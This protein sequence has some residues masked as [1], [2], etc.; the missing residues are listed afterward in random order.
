MKTETS[1]QLMTL[2]KDGI[3]VSWHGPW[4]TPS[5]HL[6]SCVV[7]HPKDGGAEAASTSAW[8]QGLPLPCPPCLLAHPSDNWRLSYIYIYICIHNLFIH[9]FGWFSGCAGCSLLCGLCSSCPEQG[10]LSPCVVQASYRGGFTCCGAQALGTRVSVVA[11]C[12]LRSC[13]SG[14]T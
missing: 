3:P 4:H 11:A 7:S 10:L 6:E 1:A 5:Q 12:G 14:F 2:G 8:G 9:L 13:G